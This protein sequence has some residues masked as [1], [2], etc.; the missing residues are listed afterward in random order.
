MAALLIPVLGVVSAL[1][2]ATSTL[3]VSDEA[4][5]GVCSACHRSTVGAVSFLQSGFASRTRWNL[6]HQVAA[7]HELA[8]VRPLTSANEG[9]PDNIG[10]RHASNSSSADFVDLAVLVPNASSDGAD[11]SSLQTVSVKQESS[12]MS[13]SD[14]ED[15]VAVVVEAPANASFGG[16]SVTDS[17][18][19]AYDASN[20]EVNATLLLPVVMDNITKLETDNGADDSSDESSLG[21]IWAKLVGVFWGPDAA[22]G[23][24]ERLREQKR[25]AVKAENYV[26]AKKLKTEIEALHDGRK[27]VG[28][29]PD[30][31][32]EQQ[33][34]SDKILAGVLLA[35][36]FL[37][38]MAWV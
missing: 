22:I 23:G 37:K 31:K 26:L 15:A 11:N 34:S 12:N 24:G 17:T 25:Q 14:F 21:H 35:M 29:K 20:E 10:F 33:H 16:Q 19:Q 36:F 28:G 8:I 5:H 27:P 38:T 9:T 13:S 4:G 32:H 2:K 30:E 1:A 6:Q 3:F 18:S 7:P